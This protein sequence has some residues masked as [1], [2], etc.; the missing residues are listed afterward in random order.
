M[1]TAFYILIYLKTPKGFE[2]FGRFYIG[3]K[4]DLARELFD[5]LKGGDEWMD[6]CILQIDL[7]ETKNDLPVNL[8]VIG[9]T[10][11]ELAENC[12]IITK[13]AFKI[14]AL[15]QPNTSK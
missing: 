14:F 8:K 9:C 15:S 3:D 11:T 10:L 4:E 12:K 6:D 2:S 13:E 5:Q 1:E 7:M